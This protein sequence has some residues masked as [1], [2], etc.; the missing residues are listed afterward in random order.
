MG[1]GLGEKPGIY[2]VLGSSLQKI[3]TQSIDFLIQ[4][5]D[6]E[7][8]A[9]ARGFAY[10]ENGHYYATFT[11]GDNTFEYDQ[12]TSSLS[13][14]PEWH[15]RQTGVTNATGFQKW[16]A[17]HGVKAYG[18]IQ[19][20]DDRSGKIG[21]LDSAVFMEYGEPIEKF[22]TTKP[23]IDKAEYLFSREVELYMGTGLGNDDVEDPQIRMDYSDDGGRT[24]NSEISRSL[25]KVG[26]FF[27]RLRWTRLGRFPVS[28]MFRWKCTEPVP[29]NVYG[30]FAN[31]E[32]TESG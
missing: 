18:E 31:A 5:Y 9:K 24:F 15:E 26:E 1:G 22:F 11:V 13:G 10:S 16:R 28:R 12:K 21:K 30:L 19:L 6:E 17:I 2:Q 25:G 7:T 29:I 23:F 3:S 27:E 8:I 32:G 20:G 14:K 4:Q